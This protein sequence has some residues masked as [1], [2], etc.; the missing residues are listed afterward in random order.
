MVLIHDYHKGADFVDLGFEFT[1]PMTV[2]DKTNVARYL[3]IFGDQNWDKID[4]NKFS[5]WKNTPLKNYQFNLTKILNQF[6]NQ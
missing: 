5:R 4:F 3:A 1:A 2:I 6:K